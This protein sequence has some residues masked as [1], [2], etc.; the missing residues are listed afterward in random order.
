VPGGLVPGTGAVL[1][2]LAPRGYW[3]EGFE[4]PIKGIRDRARV[5]TPFSGRR[6]LRLDRR[7]VVPGPALLA[8]RY[9]ATLR[10]R[11]GRARLSAVAAGST[12]TLTVALEPGAARWRRVTDTFRLGRTGPVRVRLR[13]AGGPAVADDLALARRR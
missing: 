3:R 9:R 5:R 13:V 6:G 11:G 10:V 2:P 7:A 12:I 4:N 8:G 1:A